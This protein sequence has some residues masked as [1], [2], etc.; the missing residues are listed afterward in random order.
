MGY[1]GQ[2]LQCKRGRT[3][4]LCLGTDSDRSQKYGARP[5]GGRIKDVIPISTGLFP[6]R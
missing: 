3:T 2:E 6:H 5:K 4:K 1:H